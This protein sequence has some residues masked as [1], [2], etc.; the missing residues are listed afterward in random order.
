MEEEFRRIERDSA[1]GLLFEKLYMKSRYHSF[2]DADRSSNQLLNRYIDVKPYDRT[3]IKLVRTQSDYINAN[4]VNVPKA[5]RRYI[6]TQGPLLDTLGHF[7]LMVFEQKSNCIVML[8][9]C[10]EREDIV[11]CEQY[12]PSTVGQD[13]VFK[14]VNLSITLEFVRNTKHFTVRNILL[15]DLDTNQTRNVSQFHYMIWPD[16]S[17]PSS[18]VSFLRLLAEVRKSGGLDSEDQPAVVHCSAG[19]G[20]SGTFCLIDSILAMIENQGSADNIDIS[21]T[22]VEMRDY[23]MGLIQTPTQLRFSYEAIIHGIKALERAQKLRPHA[24]NKR[25]TNGSSTNASKRAS[26]IRKKSNGTL[27]TSKSTLLID[28]LD[29]AD[30][31]SLD[32]A[33]NEVSMNESPT[34]KKQRSDPSYDGKF[35]DSHND[36]Q[37]INP[38]KLDNGVDNGASSSSDEL[39]NQHDPQLTDSI[40]NLNLNS[41]LL[42]AAS[43]S[44]PNSVLARRRDRELKL[45]QKTIDI[46]LKMKAEEIR[47]EKYMS[48]MALFR[49][50]ILYSGAAVAIGS[51]LYAFMTNNTKI[52]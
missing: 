6:L 13:M 10:I 47:R 34:L 5:G 38:S 28:A 17:E 7:W 15:K 19:I 29:N 1:W 39:S 45:A 35:F 4:E 32:E 50:S 41:P 22:L 14:D 46:K 48:R 52:H 21:N 23:R 11:K 16:F 2:S 9:K 3:R 24:S 51:I 44:N 42:T 43:S 26:R 33:F 20:R 12:W 37:T 36:D 25:V 40:N 8:N 27:K 49:K 31:D 30:S 18:P